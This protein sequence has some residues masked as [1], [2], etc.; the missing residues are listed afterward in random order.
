M[1]FCDTEREMGL[2]SPI[3]PP[4]QGELDREQVKLGLS[5]GQML[6]LEAGSGQKLVGKTWG[7]LGLSY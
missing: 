3:L 5:V 2:W 4:L 6:T 1:R 7:S